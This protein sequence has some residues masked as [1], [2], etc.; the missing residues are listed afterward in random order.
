[1]LAP[2]IVPV[3]APYNLVC[4]SCGNGYF[5]RTW[6]AEQSLSPGFAMEDINSQVAEQRNNLLE[7]LRTQVISVGSAVV[8]I[9]PQS[10]HLCCYADCIHGP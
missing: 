6:P 4:G 3:V 7:R 8:D 5:M 2:V 1:M 10:I 9:C